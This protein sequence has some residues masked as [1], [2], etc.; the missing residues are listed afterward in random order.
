MLP[1]TC[2]LAACIF[3]IAAVW[4]TTNCDTC[5]ACNS[6]CKRGA[7]CKPCLPFDYGVHSCIERPCTDN[8]PRR[9]NY[10]VPLCLALDPSYPSPFQE[11]W[12]PDARDSTIR[13]LVFSVDRLWEDL[14]CAQRAWAC[15]CGMEQLPCRC[16]VRVRFDTSTRTFPVG[17][18]VTAIAV[19]KWKPQND[20]CMCGDSILPLIAINATRWRVGTNKRWQY[21]GLDR[22]GMPYRYFF[23]RSLTDNAMATLFPSDNSERWA[24]DLCTILTHELG[25]VYGFGHGCHSKRCDSLLRIDNYCREHPDSCRCCYAG[26]M[27][28]RGMQK[29]LSLIHI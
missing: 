21:L 15:V 26:V 6:W 24:N 19:P 20:S 27:N 29:Y 25:H 3:S 14:C 28:G 1:K 18:T 8:P 12:W 10:A 2:L 16:T 23:N 22:L 5:Q 9:F 7:L 11:V 4:A 13:R 17:S